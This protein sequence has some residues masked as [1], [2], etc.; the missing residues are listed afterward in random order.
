MVLQTFYGKY[1]LSLLWVGSPTATGKIIQI[2]TA[3]RLNYFPVHR[4]RTI[5]KRGRGP[6]IKTWGQRV[7]NSC[8]T[9]T[10]KMSL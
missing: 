5:Y 6:L 1:P 9:E 8:S 7:E 3:N 2:V 10:G 4:I